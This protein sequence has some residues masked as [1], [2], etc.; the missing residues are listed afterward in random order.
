M[1]S[2]KVT[3]IYI[4][5][6]SNYWS[7]PPGKPGNAPTH[8]PETVN[9]HAGKGI[10]GDRFY[11]YKENYKG[12]ITFMSK[13]AL[14][15]LR[16]SNGGDFGYEV[17]RRNVILEGIDPLTLVGKKFKIGQ[18]VFEGMCDCDPCSWMDTAAGKGS[19]KWLYQNKKGGLRARILETGT[20]SIG[21]VLEIQ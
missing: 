5:P 4:S 21:D 1:N 12:Q 3:N 17:F 2:V 16:D 7:H 9:C 10:E 8:Q 11:D 15:E 18:A 20:L 19:F 14:E 6:E 13:D